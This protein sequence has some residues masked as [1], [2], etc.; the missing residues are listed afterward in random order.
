MNPESCLDAEVNIQS[1]Y[2]EAHWIF[3]FQ[4]ILPV[5]FAGVCEIWFWKYRSFKYDLLSFENDDFRFFQG[6]GKSVWMNGLC[7]PVA[8]WDLRS[9][10]G[11]LVPNA[12]CCSALVDALINYTLNF[13]IKSLMVC[14]NWQKKKKVL[15]WIF[16]MSLVEV[17]GHRAGKL[18]VCD[19]TP[20]SEF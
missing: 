2:L 20:G 3:Q 13:A 8:S 14:M 17:H 19:F 1:P 5:H 9:V 10:H 16:L 12:S 11:T 7:V 18:F 4:K 6:S 15:R